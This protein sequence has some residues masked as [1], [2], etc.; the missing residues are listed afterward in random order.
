MNEPVAIAPDKP[1]LSPQPLPFPV[2]GVGASAGG[3]EAFEG[4]LAGLPDSF[5]AA[6][7]LVQHLD[8]DHESLLPEILVRRTRLKVSQ[9]ADGTPIE[10]GH[11]YII[12]SASGLAVEDGVLSLTEFDAPRGF[13]RPIDDFFQSL[14][15]D[16]GPNAAAIVLSGTG[17]DGT[18]GIRH[19][20][21][22]G[23]LTVVQD[24]HEASYDGMPVSAIGTGLIDL[25]L[26]VADMGRSAQRY[27]ETRTRQVQ[28]GG[29]DRARFLDDVLQ[30][31]LDQTGHDFGYYKMNTVLRR[32]QRRMQVLEL[33]DPGDYVEA[34]RSRDGEAEALFQD[35]TINVTAFFRDPETFDQLRSEVIPDIVES[36][37][38]RPIRVWVPGCSSGEEA[39]SIAILFAEAVEGLEE[40][41]EI[42]VFATDI[43]DDMLRRAREGR[44]LP[45]SVADMPPVLLEKYFTIEDG[46]FEVVQSVRDMIRVSSHSVIK[47]PPFS[48]LD[49]ISCRNLLIY[50]D[51]ALQGRVLPLFHYALRPDGY[52]LLG[53]AENIAGRDDLFDTL[54]RQHRLYRKVG[55]GH[56]SFALPL[57]GLNPSGRTRR[58]PTAATVE[59]R[60]SRIDALSRRVMERYAP[61]HVVVDGG[62]RLVHASSRTAP[63]LELPQGEPSNRILDLASPPLRAAIRAVLG[64]MKQR[65]RR[66]V[67]RGIQIP[68]DDGQIVSVDLVADPMDAAETLI[69]FR[70]RSRRE[71]EQDGDA[72]IGD[73]HTEER[74]SEL[75]DEL[76]EARSRLRTTVEELET[77]NEELKSS[78]EEMMSMNEEL[79]SANEELSTVNDE[80]K[81]KLDELANANA[82]QQNY[83]GATQIAIVFADAQRRI[84]SFTPAARELFRLKPQDK[85]RL[86]S[87]IRADLPL[88]LLDDAMTQALAGED[89]GIEEIRVGDETYN[90]RARPYRDGEG[91]IDG[92]ILVLDDVSALAKARSLADQAERDAASSRAEIERLYENAPLGI[93]LVDEGLRYRRINRSLADYNGYGPEEHIGRT[94]TEM[95]PEIGPLLEQPLARVF[96]HGET[97]SQW[98]LEAPAP[99][100]SD[101]AEAFE[102]DM[103]PVTRDDEGNVDSAGIIVHRV[104]DQWMMEAE[105]RRLM[106]ELQHRVKNSLA[107]VL[108]V[109]G[110]T[111][112][113][114]QDRDALANALVRRIG[115]LAATHALLTSSDFRAVPFRAI[116]EPELAPY[117]EVSE[118]GIEGPSMGLNAK[119]A[120]TLTMVFHELATNAAKYG[121]LATPEGSLDVRWTKDADGLRICWQEETTG[122]VSEPERKGF[123]TRFIDRALK[124]DLDGKA[125]FEWL[126]TGLRCEI[127]IPSASLEAR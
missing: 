29:F 40:P 95:L 3:L 68:T 105:L 15:L 46:A 85:G 125:R 26:P 48:R 4:L 78:N 25:V 79:Q 117:R 124:H 19:I 54:S 56:T 57:R 58:P 81:S 59:Q 8:P 38:G 12:P 55:K 63:F 5:E 87:D 89:T 118:I 74:I 24:P 42:R 101:Q 11:V 104:T 16:Q 91:R 112:R 106:A 2:V 72:D 34:L 107:T 121:A 119:T 102:L 92:A 37:K 76:G 116:L 69:V 77:S 50:F 84:R 7:I 75:E 127:E 97:L 28:A 9:I 35:L 64:S 82:D 17:G 109:V 65:R 114:T 86:I 126:G 103:Y 41:P 14:A 83:L 80:L 45:S 23:G 10:A 115:A 33:V 98:E 60:D 53:S 111:V 18:V 96:D 120:V 6:F 36:A 113:S 123:G 61:P 122:P 47:D 88:D 20:K 30:T 110:Q 108:A 1:E 93:A 73:F 52:L 32:I 94:I 66:M 43:D 49:L 51:S 13:R 100:D 27:F 44:Y 99:Q 39:Y 22:A 31:V 90:F 67:R 71:D 62:G 21:E 70:E